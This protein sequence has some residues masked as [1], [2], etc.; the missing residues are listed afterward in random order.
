M[1]NWKIRATVDVTLIN[2]MSQRHDLDQLII[3][4]QPGVVPAVLVLRST[5]LVVVLVL[6]GALLASRGGERNTPT[7]NM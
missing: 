6:V 2:L 5:R 7:G 4:L 3:S 1:K